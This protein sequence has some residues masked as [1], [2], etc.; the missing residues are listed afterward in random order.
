MSPT[1]YSVNSM[2]VAAVRRTLTVGP[3]GGT[4][5]LD[6]RLAASPGQVWSAC[7]EPDR[8]RRWLGTVA[9]RARVGATVTL[10]M[11]ADD[12][13]TCR[14]DRC[15]APRLLVCGWQ[16]SR[17]P[18]S[19]VRLELTAEGTGTRLVLEHSGLEH[20]GLAHGGLAADGSPGEGGYGPAGFGA[21][22]EDFLRALGE[23]LERADGSATDVPWAEVE[24][25]LLPRWRALLPAPAAPAAA[26]MTDTSDT[27]DI[28]HTSDTSDTS[29]RADP[30][31]PV[32]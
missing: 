7:T 14:I 10:A 5:T 26:D 8:L 28:S 4:V 12:V 19:V 9:G 31:G 21:G 24:Q 6:R 29:D 20:I 25:T 16:E 23:H 11:T 1:L 15:E 2:D 17:G 13:V 18:D 3:T 22:W 32:A 30:S 27:S